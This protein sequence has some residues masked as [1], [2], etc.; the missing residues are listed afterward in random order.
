[1]SY[2]VQLL[3][4]QI[5]V[6]FLSR[7]AWL[8]WHREGR[9]CCSNTGTWIPLPMSQA[10][11]WVSQ[12]LPSPLPAF[13]LCSDP[14]GCCCA[15]LL[16]LPA[17]LGTIGCI[18]PALMDGAPCAGASQVPSGLT[19]GMWEG[20]SPSLQS[21]A[22]VPHLHPSVRVLQAERGAAKILCRSGEL[23]FVFTR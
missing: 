23:R 21:P 9:G 4:A 19:A 20:K 15:P 10:G 5:R 12:A 13:S 14:C 22:P 7:P 16:S 1:M 18:Y 11:P 3:Y 17:A 8:Q 2:P 6:S